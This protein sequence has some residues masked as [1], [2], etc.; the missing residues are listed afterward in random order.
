MGQEPGE[1]GQPHL[2]S[3]SGSSLIPAAPS[4]S[5]DKAPMDLFV[6][7]APIESGRGAGIP[8]IGR[9][10]KRITGHQPLDSA[11]L[12]SLGKGRLQRKDRGRPKGWQGFLHPP[13]PTAPSACAAPG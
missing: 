8:V 1:T 13:A 2:T 6:A 10:D 5:I 9:G 7:G 3:A 11:Q 12:T 4:T